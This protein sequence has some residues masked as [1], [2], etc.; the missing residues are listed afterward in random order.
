MA[1]DTVSSTLNPFLLMTP[2]YSLVIPFK[3]EE[4]NVED[5]ILELVPV[6]ES[7]NAPWE[8]LCIDDGST[9]QTRQILEKLASQF[10]QIRLLI[11]DQNYGQTSAFDAGFQSA[12]GEFLITLDGDGQNDPRDIPKLVEAIDG[13]DL[14]CGRRVNRRDPWMKRIISRLA[15]FVRSRV[16]RDGMHDTGC[17]LKIYRTSCLRKIKLFHGLHRFLPALF[18]IEGFR[19]CEIPVN[20]RERT[21]G[22]S[23]YH[24][25]NRLL[26]PV[27]DLFAVYWMRK[28]HLRYRIAKEWPQ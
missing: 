26:G 15:N 18:T 16:C 7:L 9:D 25:F 2:L 21:K 3:D 4:S 8:L 20:H 19:T 11:F 27:W 14:V 6:M 23:K 13:Y 22:K 5:L 28:K 24:F 1:L 17:S 10:P 12:K